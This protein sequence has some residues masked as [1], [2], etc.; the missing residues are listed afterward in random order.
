[1]SDRLPLDLVLDDFVAWR[2]H[3]G[4]ITVLTERT[5]WHPLIDVEDWLPILWAI[6]RKRA[7]EHFPL[8]LHRNLRRRGNLRILAE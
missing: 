5:P 6:C 8:T 7:L 2:D 1:M 4:R 3:L